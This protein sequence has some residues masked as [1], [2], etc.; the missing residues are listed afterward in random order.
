MIIEA[1]IKG[2]FDD[3][4]GKSAV[5]IVDEA[6]ILH[7]VKWRV[8]DTWEYDGEIV[9]ADQ[10]NCEILAAVYALNWCKQHGKNT[11]NIYAN[12]TTCQKWYYRHEFPDGRVMGK[13]F[14]Q[15][16]GED[17]DVYADYLPK[18]DENNFNMLVND[19]AESVK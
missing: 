2:R 10:F 13:A 15:T 17:I 5:V 16:Q 19:L 12:T 1:Y 18:K 14:I 6:K 9:K 7:Q 3:G 8:P 4:I 11:V